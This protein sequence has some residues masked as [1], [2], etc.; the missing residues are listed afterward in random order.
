MSAFF[1]SALVFVLVIVVIG[2]IFIA[3]TVSIYNKLVALKAR[4][5]NAFA[6]I[7]VQLTRR[8]D[9]I[10]NI[11]EVAKGYMK[12][13]SETLTKVIEARN[14]AVN[15]LKNASAHPEDPASI[16][17]LNTAEARLS[18]S[19]GGLLVQL[20]AYPELKANTVM[21]QL[22]EELSSTENRVAFARQAF[23]DAV[24]T[25][26]VQRNSFPA[27]VVANAFGHSKDATLLEF[28]NVEAIQSAPKVSF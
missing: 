10:P 14:E 22:N 18:G 3:Y 19:F 20:E 15:S 25:Y 21:A 6:Q 27:S 26:N 5:E 28:A 13:E 7:E 11:I 12:H 2:A 1:T 4:F 8:Y 16:A 9:L 17:A 23:N 24:T